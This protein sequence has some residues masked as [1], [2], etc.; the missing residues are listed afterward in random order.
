MVTKLGDVGKRLAGQLYHFTREA[1]GGCLVLARVSRRGPYLLLVLHFL[2][3]FHWHSC[4][5][6][7]YAW[8]GDSSLYG[9][10]RQIIYIYAKTH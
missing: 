5:A 1:N 10:G 8:V 7:E 9:A 6:Q 3:F 2:H 4:A